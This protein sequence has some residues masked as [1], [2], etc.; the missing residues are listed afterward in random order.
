MLLCRYEQSWP[1]RVRNF[2]VWVLAKMVFNAI[3][4]NY[5][6]SSFIVSGAVGRCVCHLACTGH[7]AVRC[8]MLQSFAACM[9]SHVAPAT[10]LKKLRMPF[11]D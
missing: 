11:V 10:L 6:A 4:L 5:A 1:A 3:I 7:L 2:P 9:P 8:A